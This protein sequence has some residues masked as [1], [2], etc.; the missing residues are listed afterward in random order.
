MT[1]FLDPD[2]RL[3]LDSEGRLDMDLLCIDCEYNLRTIRP[4]EHCPE[5]GKAVAES[6]RGDVLALSNV[7]W[8]RTVRRGFDTLLI[9][10]VALILIVL[11]SIV[12]EQLFPMASS[13]Q[14]AE[15]VVYLIPMVLSFFAQ[16]W[17]TAREP[18]KITPHR[19]KA[20]TL[21][22]NARLFLILSVVLG[23]IGLGIMLLNTLGPSIDWTVSTTIEAIGDVID[24]VFLF[25]LFGYLATLAA[26][27]P[28]A[29]LI[30]HTHWVKWGLCSGAVIM[31]AGAAIFLSVI[32]SQLNVSVSSGP[33]SG[34]PPNAQVVGTPQVSTH[35]L[36][37]GDTVTTTV[38]DYDNG[39]NVVE[40]VTTD[41]SGNVIH[42]STSTNS[43]GGL[44][45][46]FS[47]AMIAGQVAVGI[48]GLIYFVF[49]IWGLVL[50]FWYRR[51]LRTAIDD[52]VK[53]RQ[54]NGASMA[55]WASQGPQP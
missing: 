54:E 23:V 6:A 20:E 7:E 29:T 51:R 9:M 8:L 42:T 25:L 52:A 26:R 41:A 14:Y 55:A 28:Q 21:R 32:N 11:L 44:G 4:D 50:I 33:S 31:L 13:L 30:R 16:W 34:P 38:T 36:G 48:G 27:V 35:T 40:V 17:I 46:S 15:F 22:H 19:Q 24:I 10:F 2:P 12:M 45:M 37:D 1:T 47:P 5:C 53:L 39:D 49:A 3:V 18:G 43:F